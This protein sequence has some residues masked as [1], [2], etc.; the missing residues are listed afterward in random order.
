MS[1]SHCRGGYHARI[2]EPSTFLLF[3]RSKGGNAM[4]QWYHAHR[5]AVMGARAMVSSTHYLATTAGLEILKGGG[6]APAGGVGA[7]LCIN[8]LEPHLTNLGGVA[9]IMVYEAGTGQ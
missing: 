8:V 6:N 4:V 9:S 7:G 1:P 5:P 3:A 2:G